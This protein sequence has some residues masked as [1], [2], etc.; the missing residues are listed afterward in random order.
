MYLA[1][2]DT[3]LLSLVIDLKTAAAF[4]INIPA[5]TPLPETSANVK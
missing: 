5:L 4:A 3:S 1:I 2:V